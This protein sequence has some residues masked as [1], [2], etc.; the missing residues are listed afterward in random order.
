MTVIPLQNRYFHRISNKIRLFLGQSE[1]RFDLHRDV[2]NSSLYRSTQMELAP[3]CDH[4]GSIEVIL[5]TVFRSKKGVTEWWE[6]LECPELTVV[7]E[8]YEAS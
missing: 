6:C 5:C 8:E 7:K 1:E 3:A 4:C 2:T